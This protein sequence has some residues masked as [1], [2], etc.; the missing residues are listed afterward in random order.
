M[1]QQGRIFITG[2]THGYMSMGKLST[3]NWAEGK[4]LTKKDYV[5]IAGDFGLIWSYLRTKEEEH[6]IKWLDDQPWTTLFI[7]G[8]HENFDVLNKLPEKEMFGGIVGIVSR[9]V[10]HLRRGNVYRINSQKILT[11][12]GAHSH[13]R[14]YRKW[15]ETM[16]KQ[17]E[18]TDEDINNAKIALENADFCVDHVVTHCAPAMYARGSMPQDMV[19]YWQPDGSEERLDDFLK[20]SGISFQKWWCGHYH[21]DFG[22]IMKGDFEC[23]HNGIKELTREE[24]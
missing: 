13:D 18:I 15:G 8:N 5:I 12:G 24:I 23:L 20:T 3:R 7:D 22:P 11:I 19:Q 2:D 10:Y 21:T 1:S 16:W 4:T 6:W 9:S 17:E 14:E